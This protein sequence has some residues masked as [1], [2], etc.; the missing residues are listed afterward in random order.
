MQST[1]G[2]SAEKVRAVAAG[3]GF[4][5]ADKRLEAFFE[6]AADGIVFTDTQGTILT[7]NKVGLRM[8]GYHKSEVTGKNGLSF[9]ARCSWITALRARRKTLKEG[10]AKDVELVLRTNVGRQVPVSIDLKILKGAKGQPIGFAGIVRPG[11]LSAAEELP[12]Q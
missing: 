6:S 5:I 1:R 3:E 2:N 12:T 10:F 7:I 8:L 11:C 4:R 9:F